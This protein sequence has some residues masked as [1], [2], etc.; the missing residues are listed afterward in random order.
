MHLTS[1][2]RTIAFISGIFL[3][4]IVACTRISSTELGGELIPTIDGV[5]TFDTTLELITDSFEESDTTRIYKT[6]AH[7]LGILSNDPIFGTTAAS[8]NFELLPTFFPFAFSGTKDSTS[9]DSAV[10]ILS[11]KSFYGDSMQSLR[12]NVQEIS[13]NTPLDPYKV[14]PANFPQ[15]YPISTVGN[16]ADT[17][18]VDIRRLGDSVYNRFESANYQIRIRLKDAF[19]K[20]LI[21]SYD[22]TNAYHSDTTFRANFGGFSIK[23]EVGNAANALLYI[24]LTDTNSKLGLYYNTKS[25]G[26]LTRD[27]LVSY[28]RLNTYASGDINY[29][30][31]NRAGSEVAN[32]LTTTSKPDSIVYV[33]TS[34]GTYARIKVP[35]LQNLSNRIIHRAELIAEQVP[36]DANL[37]TID[38]LMS[39][40]GVL[41]LSAW[42]FS[43]SM[44]R[45]IPNDFV[46][47]TSGL[48][49]T[50]TFGGYLS[51]KS[52]PGYDQIATYNFNLTRYVQGIVSR[53]DSSFVLR[54]SAPANDSISYIA[55]YPNLT[56]AQTYYLTPS[57]GNN[58]ADG[59][60]RLGGGTHSRFRMRLRIVYSK[61]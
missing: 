10:L 30:T 18:V 34:P 29:I 16:L 25:T 61:I 50:A 22:S 11:C 44:K 47:G 21:L 35:A 14:Y 33:Q 26:S 36:D 58:V 37:N 41:L 27:T 4:S 12:L 5:N 17:K 31:R 20:R 19:A 39:P 24:N 51:Y 1:T 9:V 32:R 46:Y 40:P 6:D 2:L 28:F 7:V 45:N 60:I 52:V 48:P 8:L 38:K 54:L 53:K 15:L 23:P 55:P 49:N 3:F 13:T 43:K 42:D 57:I 59:R 56:A